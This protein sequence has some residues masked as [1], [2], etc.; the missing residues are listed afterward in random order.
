MNLYTLA[1][2]DYFSLGTQY[3]VFDLQLTYAS[4]FKRD[5][6][7]KRDVTVDT[8]QSISVTREIKVKPSP[9]GNNI[10]PDT[11]TESS[12]HSSGS[13]MYNV[14]LAIIGVLAGSCCLIG[15]II[16]GLLYRRKKHKKA[17]SFH[18]EHK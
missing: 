1:D 17:Y 8:P 16:A 6:N 9:Q 18:E 14:L 3:L 5:N 7:E 2:L 15:V 10:P 11:N 4:P 13:S 12:S